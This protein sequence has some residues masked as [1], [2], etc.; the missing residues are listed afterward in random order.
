MFASSCTCAH[1]SARDAARRANPA[2]QRSAATSGLT[3]YAPRRNPRPS[4]HPGL[5]SALSSFGIDSTEDNAA[6]GVSPV[7]PPAA[8]H[9]SKVTSPPANSK[10]KLAL[11]FGRLYIPLGAKFWWALGSLVVVAILQI[12]LSPTGPYAWIAGIAN[13]VVG[14]VL[15]LVLQPLPVPVSNAT[16]AEFAVTSLVNTVRSVASSRTA[17]AEIVA[18]GDPAKLE[19][20]LQLV[21][22]E[23]NRTLRHLMDSVSEWDKIEP[24]VTARVAA[25]IARRS[26]LAKQFGIEGADV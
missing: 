24:G 5:D 20:G 8:C 11:H 18:V 12:F 7:E 9:N 25:E 6:V 21:D 14:V 17:L 19:V 4:A 13:V 2:A 10:V 22:A 3:R 16:H 15:G 1:D 23:L 26:E